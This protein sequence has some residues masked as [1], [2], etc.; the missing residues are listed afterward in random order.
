MQP[1]VEQ[2]VQTLPLALSRNFP[3]S[4]VVHT[5]VEASQ[6]V[7]PE[8]VTEH[9]M[10]APGGVVM[11]SHCV[12]ALQLGGGMGTQL[13][14]ESTSSS[15]DTQLVHNWPV[16]SQVAQAAGQAE[17]ELPLMNSFA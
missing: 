16:E 12:P 7:Q 5:P 17:Q 2:F 9:S 14:F 1:T 8:V 4:Q 3:C 11:S 6:F 15:A 13:P 10:Q